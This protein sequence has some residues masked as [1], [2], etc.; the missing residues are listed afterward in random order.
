MITSLEGGYPIKLPFLGPGFVIEPQGQ[1]IW[2]QV[3]FNDAFDGEGS[4]GLGTTSG[5]TGRLGLRGQWA[6]P[7]AN[8]AL[9]QP[10]AG[11]NLWQDWGAGA[12]TIFGPVDQVMLA[13]RTPRT[14]VLAGLTAKLSSRLSLYGEGGYHFVADPAGDDI[15]R[16]GVKGD[17]GLR[18]T[19]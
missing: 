1:I 19:W 10:Y 5:F 2:Q 12:T 15:R 18:Y 14:E 3:S 16:N 13:E 8:G 11:V 4:V 9:W 6:I 7:G 17:I